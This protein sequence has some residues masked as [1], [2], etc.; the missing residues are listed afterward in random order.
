MT[1]RTALGQ[2]RILTFALLLGAFWTLTVAADVL[3]SMEG[4]FAAASG[5][6]VGS[7]IGTVAITGLMGVLVMAAL[8]GMLVYLFGEVGQTDPSPEPWPPESK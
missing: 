3:G 5:G 8:L 2:S 6:V 7:Y 4:L 1:L